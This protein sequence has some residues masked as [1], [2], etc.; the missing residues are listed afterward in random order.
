MHTGSKILGVALILMLNFQ[1]AMILSN[2]SIESADKR[3]EALAKKYIEQLLEMNPETATNLGDHR[4]DNRLDDYSL[5]GVE[6]DR[7]FNQ[8]YLKALGAIPAARLSQVNSVDYRIMRNRLEYNLFQLEEL[9]EYEWNPLRYNIGGAIYALISRDFAPLKERMLSVKE[10]LKAIPAVLAQAK[11]NLKN[12]PRVHTETAISQNTGTIS[13]VRDELQPFIEKVPELKSEIAPVQAAAVRALEDYGAWL[14]KDLLPRSTADFRLGDAKYRRKLHLALESDLSKEEILRRAEADLK[15]TQEAMYEV[16]LPL[17]KKYFP[18]ENSSSR[19]TDRKLVIKAVLARLAE[20]HP[21]NETIVPLA[22]EQVKS[23]TEFV[24]QHNLVSVPEEPVKVIVMPEFTRGV[25]V[26]Y[27]NAVGP[28]ERRGETF[29]AISPTPRDWTRERTESFFR[30]YNN[31]MVLDVTVHEAMPG[32]Y[33]QLAHANKFNAPTRLR[34][35][36]QSNTFAEGWAV[37]AEQMMAERGFGGPEVRMQQL[38]LKLRT[39]INAILDQ[40]IHTSGMTEKEALALMMNEGFQEEGEA[41]GKW[42]RAQLTSAQLSNYYVGSL[43]VID[44]RRA[45]EA[46]MG[47]TANFRQMHDTMLSFG[48]PAPKYVK[49]LMGL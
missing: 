15:S 16:A 45:Y 39:I 20:A 41:S 19:L 4:F 25:A 36:F 48:S 32:H 14:S 43:E 6:R 27:C 7:A 30:E 2:A 35:I 12:P 23:A 9:R 21:N 17:Y 38:K 3:F 1:G 5:K 22:S 24:R 13:L 29:Y 42:R 47:D 37:Y 18:A 26:A 8:K 11:A 33:L 49:E 34:A 31:Y 40:K 44:I 46:K 10:R 28:F